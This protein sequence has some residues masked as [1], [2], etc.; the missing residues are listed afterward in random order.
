MRI[1]ND[2]KAQVY[3]CQMCELSSQCRSPIPIHSPSRTAPRFLVLGEAPGQVEDQKGEPFVG[4]AG[5]FLKRALKK[6]GLSPSDGGYLNTVSCYPRID[7]T[8]DAAHVS[9]CSNNLFDQLALYPTIPT[10]VCGSVALTALLPHATI[11]YAAGVPIIAHNRTLFP[12]YH[13]SYILRSRGVMESWE[14]QLRV[15]SLLVNTDM[16]PSWEDL[17]RTH[18]LYCSAGYLPRTY[19]CPRHAGLWTKD[20]KP[21]KRK[22]VP[23]PQLF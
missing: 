22:P 16:V 10:L 12:I 5:L 6:A 17:H 15:F 3:T 7:K 18:C 21:P 20:T 8:P 19:T 23:H 13:P 2:V 9:A 14:R 1:L 11:T 4:P